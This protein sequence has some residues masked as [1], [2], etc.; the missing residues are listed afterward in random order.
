MNCLKKRGHEAINLGEWWNAGRFRGDEEGQEYIYLKHFVYVYESSNN[1]K[2][3]LKNLNLLHTS[4][5]RKL[6]IFVS[7]TSKCILVNLL[8]L[9]HIKII[10]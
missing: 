3:K 2:S 8:C 4:S 5:K 6:Y 9:C 7:S 1:E 10:T